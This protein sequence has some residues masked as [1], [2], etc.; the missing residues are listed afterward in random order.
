[1]MWPSMDGEWLVYARL[2][3]TRCQKLD[4]I[5]YATGDSR[6][7]SIRHAV[8]PKVGHSLEFINN[9]SLTRPA[10]WSAARDRTAA[11]PP[12]ERRRDTAGHKP[13]GQRQVSNRRDILMPR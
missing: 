10:R 1:M 8:V 9:Q 6:A 7:K 12:G 3:S 11:R 4:F 5:D 13:I 2:N